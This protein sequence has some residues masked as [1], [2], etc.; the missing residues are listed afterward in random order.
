MLALGLP[1]S[2]PCTTV[3]KVCASGMK[4]IMMAS[5]SLMCGHQVRDPL[6]YLSLG[7]TP[8]SRKCQMSKHI[9]VVAVRFVLYYCSM[10]MSVLPV[11]M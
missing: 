2:T 11:C 9:Y 3:N 4:A 6:F 8:N 1:I 5:Q 7:R 10:F